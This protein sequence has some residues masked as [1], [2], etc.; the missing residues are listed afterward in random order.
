MEI[1]HRGPYGKYKSNVSE[2]VLL[3]TI[4]MCHN[5]A[6]RTFPFLEFERKALDGIWSRGCAGA[7]R[8]RPEEACQRR[9]NGGGAR[10]GMRALAGGLGSARGGAWNPSHV[11]WRP[12]LSRTVV[13][14][15]R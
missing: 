6:E 2:E 14:A 11:R 4:H 3:S 10:A 13:R 15:R 12:R 7:R 9:R 8:F 1:L 5:F